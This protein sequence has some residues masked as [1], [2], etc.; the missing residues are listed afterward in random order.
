[1]A[2]NLFTKYHGALVDTLNYA[3]VL[4]GKTS[5]EFRWDGVKGIFLTSLKTVPLVDY[6]RTANPVASSRY[7]TPVEVED[8]QQYMELRKDRSIPLVIDKGNYQEQGMLKKAGKVIA[9]EINEQVAPELQRYALAEYAKNAGQYATLTSGTPSVIIDLMG[10]EAMFA[11]A[12]IPKTERYVCVD[13]TYFPT[14]RA[15]MLPADNISDKLIMRGVAGRIGTLNIIETP[16]DDM[17]SNVVALA[18]WKRAVLNPVTINET[19]LHTNPEGVSGALI[20][21]RYRYDAFVVGMYA[22][23]V[24]ALLDA[25]AQKV[26]ASAAST[27]RAITV[28]SGTNVKYTTDGTDPR[29]S[30]SAKTLAASGTVSSTE[31]PVG[32]VIKT[33]AID[34]NGVKY[35]SAVS[36]TVVA[37]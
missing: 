37:S 20:N 6:N 15:S 5:N 21:F 10:I 32:T 18:W 34:P 16:H 12:R 29:Y 22:N 7:G 14:I 30:N 25:N 13:A 33:V 24:V 27:A 17:P 23:G 28:A 8:H 19:D 9:A 1:M 4:S 11:N 26:A 36:E 3:N 2:I 31:A 35:P